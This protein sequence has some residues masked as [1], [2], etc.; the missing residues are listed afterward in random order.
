M[1]ENNVEAKKMIGKIQN[2]LFLLACILHLYSYIFGYRFFEG[3]RSIPRSIPIQYLIIDFPTY[4]PHIHTQAYAHD[5]CQ[6]R[7]IDHVGCLFRKCPPFNNPRYPPI[8]YLPFNTSR[9]IPPVQYP[10]SIPYWTE[11]CRISTGDRGFD[12]QP[13]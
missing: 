8:Q 9:S 3:I 10:R 5:K 13:Y 2:D 4:T 12:T 7:S 6:F 1:A 11:G